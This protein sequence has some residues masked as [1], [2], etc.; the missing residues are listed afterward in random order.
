[1]FRSINNCYDWTPF[2]LFL[3]SLQVLIHH[4][5]LTY[6][7]ISCDHL[8]D[9]HCSHMFH[10]HQFHLFIGHHCSSDLLSLVTLLFCDA[11]CTSDFIVLFYYK[12]WQSLAL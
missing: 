9:V 11:Y 3:T 7:V 6:Y 4:V 12:Y 10:L 2:L 5:I 1:M 8:C